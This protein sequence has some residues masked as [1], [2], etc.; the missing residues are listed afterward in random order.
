[1]A[2]LQEQTDER[3]RWWRRGDGQI[4]M[5][6]DPDHIKRVLGEGWQEVASPMGDVLPAATDVTT[7]TPAP[8]SP[9]S[10]EEIQAR[11]NAARAAFSGEAP[12]PAATSK[13]KP[14]RKA[15]SPGEAG[16]EA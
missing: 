3:R 7:D 12:T 1:M 8:E 16:E 2:T 5:I 4:F 15:V 9:E 11:N 10:P 14:I 6:A 13:A